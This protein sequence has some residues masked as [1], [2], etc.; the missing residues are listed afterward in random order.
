M[1]KV[2][3]LVVE[4]NPDEELLALRAL[5]RSGI[6][7]DVEVA[8]TGNH[9]IVYLQNCIDQGWTGHQLPHLILLDLHLPDISGL[10][11]LKFIRNHQEIAIIP[12]VVLTSSSKETDLMKGYELGA[13]SYIQKPLELKEFVEQLTLLIKYWVKKNRFPDQN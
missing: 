5:K 12:T 2:K 8:R 1:N 13:N 3:V 11:I 4:D 6:P 9:A 7:C 10:D